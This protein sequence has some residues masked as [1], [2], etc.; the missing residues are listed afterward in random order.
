MLLAACT[1][2][3]AANTPPTLQ[4]VALAPGVYA[5][6]GTSGVP[7][8]YNLGRIGNA[9]F[10]VGERGVVAI[11]TGTSYAHGQAL[12]AAITSVTDKPVRLAIVTHTRAEFLFGGAAFRERGIPVRMHAATAKLMAAR[13]ET[14]LKTL[15]QTLGDEP[16]RGTA[17]YVADQTF[18]ATH[19]LDLIGR[20]LRVLHFGHS[21]GPG[22]SA[23]FDEQSGVLFAGGLL[24]HER[25]PDIQDADL[26]GWRRAL[27]QLRALP[28]RRI[29]PGHGPATVPTLIDSVQR[30]LQQLETRTRA[31][32][33]GGTSLADAIDAANL[34]EFSR[35]DQY[36]TI[37]RRN[38]SIAYLRFEREA[39]LK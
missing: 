15:R 34:P 31:L 28:I 12:L 21:S 10:V 18:D 29:V 25:I 1:S 3:H 8:E 5:V 7:D 20:P 35:W 17:M 27:E 38:A 13:C 24:D 23:V 22:D 32:L 14:C 16:M 37:H 33:Q 9:G 11:D 39:F 6:Q 2:M 36:D 4:S 26:T 19:T 30:Y